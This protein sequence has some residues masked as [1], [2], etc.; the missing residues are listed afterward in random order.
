V[1]FDQ[2]NVNTVISGC[3]LLCL[4]LGRFVFLPYQRQNIAKAGGSY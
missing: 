3:N 2:A 1:E 4:G